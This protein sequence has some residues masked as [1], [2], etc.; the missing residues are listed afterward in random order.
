MKRDYVL[1]NFARELARRAGCREL[2]RQV[3]VFWNSRLR[4]TAGMACYNR[5]SIFLNP[6][7][8]EVSNREVQRT[9]RHE[10][11]HFV[12]QARAGRRRILP[13][14][15]E[16]REACRDLGIA[17][18]PRCHN[19]PF[20]PRRLARR[21]FYKCPECSTV[22][23]RVHPVKRPVACLPCCR[24]YNGGKYSARFR[25]IPIERPQ[26]LAA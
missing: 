24:R 17:N 12:A 1:E 15:K 16:W 22:L 8:L 25:F 9:L 10:L 13:H 5:R 20:K 18:E 21:Y 7:L 19:L 2:A 14:G 4:T 6:R 3:M 23:A 11:A 26:R